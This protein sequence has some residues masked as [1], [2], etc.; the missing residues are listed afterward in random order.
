MRLAALLLGAAT[1][2]TVGVLIFPTVVDPKDHPLAPRRA[3]T[4]DSSAFTKNYT[5][6]EVDAGPEDPCDPEHLRQFFDSFELEHRLAEATFGGYDNGG[7]YKDSPSG[8]QP[9]LANVSAAFRERGWLLLSHTSYSFMGNDSVPGNH[10]W[11]VRPMGRLIEEFGKLYQ[12]AN[13]GEKDGAFVWYVA[14]QLAADP[15]TGSSRW[16]QYLQ[17]YSFMEGFNHNVG[18]AC[19]YRCCLLCIYMPAID[20]SL[21]DCRCGLDAWG[22]QADP[23]VRRVDRSPRANLY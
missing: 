19:C 13:I 18:G 6:M 3:W 11:N 2:A 16:Q 10:S 9:C 15:P 21:C 23:D 20:R 8:W 14:Q 12:G 4:P 22:C 1:P 17:F 5:M 7:L